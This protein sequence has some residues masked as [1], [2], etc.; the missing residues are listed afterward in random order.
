LIWINRSTGDAR[1]GG[2]ADGRPLAVGRHPAD[3]G[4][5]CDLDQDR[6]VTVRVSYLDVA[7]CPYRARAL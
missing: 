2:A 5:V 1:T 6:L 3:V 4:L 7:A